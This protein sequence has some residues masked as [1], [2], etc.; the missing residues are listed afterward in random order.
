MFSRSLDPG[1]LYSEASV[2][3]VSSVGIDSENLRKRIFVS[4]VWPA[5]S[6][7]PGP[8]RVPAKFGA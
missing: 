5:A 6:A 7:V 3:I 1:Q 8:L 4:R 2:G